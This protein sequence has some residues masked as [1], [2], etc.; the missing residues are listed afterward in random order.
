M[1]ANGNVNPDYRGPRA[2]DNDYPSLA[3]H[4]PRPPTT[5]DVLYK[6]DAAIGR[7]R[8][9][10]WSD[11]HHL[12]LPDLSSAQM[13]GVVDLWCDEHRV[14][15]ADPAIKQ[16]LIFENKGPEV[17]ASNLHP[18]GQIY[19]YP[20]VTDSAQRMRDSQSEY[21][22]KNTTGSLLRNILDHPNVVEILVEQSTYCS[23]IVPFAAR[24]SYET[25]VI[26]HRQV[27]Y[28]TD[29]TNNELDDL[30][31]VYQRQAKRYDVLF[32]RKSPNITL[33][34]NAPCDENKHNLSWHFHIAMQPPLRDLEKVKYLAGAEAGS[35]NIIN[36]L[37]PER[38]AEQLR[39][40]MI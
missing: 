29:L 40:C 5:D 24:F 6:R 7:C 12:T 25:W 23:V 19:A 28:I 8:V 34:H 21:S 9:L 33:L 27:P 38:A 26:P 4:A 17:G 15:S 2:M 37:Q 18:H 14:L 3:P 13:R 36:P 35:N 16:V 11:K 10:C 39:Q 1:R 31:Q 32:R 30:A 22:Q 20:F